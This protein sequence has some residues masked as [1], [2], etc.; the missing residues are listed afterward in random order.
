MSVVCDE[1]GFLCSHSRII[2]ADKPFDTQFPIILP[3]KTNFV[4]LMVRKV[5]YDLDRFGWSY[6][7]AK[8]QER[9]WILRR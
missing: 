4:E 3:K 1:K 2:N 6:V 5:H 9:F 8:I 7:L